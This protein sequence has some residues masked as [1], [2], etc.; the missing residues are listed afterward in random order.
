MMTMMMMM[1]KMMINLLGV[2][3]H[4]IPSLRGAPMVTG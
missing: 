2:D 1:M 3:G 4:N